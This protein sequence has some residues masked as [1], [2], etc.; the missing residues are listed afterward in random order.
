MKRIASLLLLVS[1]FALPVAA[2]RAQLLKTVK[3]RGGVAC[4]VSQGLLG[5]SASDEK[6]GWTGFDV[7]LCRAVAAAIFN[8]ASKVKFVPLSASDRFNALRSGAVD[9]LSRNTT[10][11]MSRETSFGLDFAA[12]TY[13]DG[14][15]FLIRSAL[16]AES[17]LELDGRSVC[18]QTGTTTEL[19]LADYFRANKM[20]YRL[21]AFATADETRNAYDSGRCDVLT[22]DVSQ[23]YAERLKLA[24]PDDHV[25]L[26]EIISKEPLA[27]VVRDGDDQWL[28]IVKWTHF[29]MINAEELG[30]SSKTIEQ[31]M[32]SEKPDV[33]R[34]V[35][36]EGAY[37]EELG[38]TKDWAARIVKL[39][40]I[41]ARSS[42]ATSE[43]DPGSVSRVGST[44]C[45]A[46][47]ASNMR[48]RSAE[49]DRPHS[50]A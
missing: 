39:V 23:L 10:W 14:Q 9:V 38:L 30:V 4:G 35:G 2:A 26:S 6:G 3:E 45:G 19:N 41:M 40:E 27:P 25:I 21:V 46:K 43:P 49:I 8:D 13:Y 47:V 7:D 11:T 22:S 18:A 33:K 50:P 17:A 31:A 20:T 34:L 29:A 16:N 1:F 28:K 36:T 32:K 24:K 42:N 37:G 5:F 15:G 48:P 12:T 44:I